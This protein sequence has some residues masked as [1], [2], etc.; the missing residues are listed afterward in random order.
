MASSTNYFVTNF[1]VYSLKYFP[2]L[3]IRRL[4]TLV[5]AMIKRSVYETPTQWWLIE[6]TGVT[7]RNVGDSKAATAP[8]SSVGNLRE[9]VQLKSP[10]WCIKS[11][12]RKLMGRLTG[13]KLP[14]QSSFHLPHE[15]YKG[16]GLVRISRRLLS[17]ELSDSCHSHKPYGAFISL[18][19]NRSEVWHLEVFTWVI[20]V[21]LTQDSND[22]I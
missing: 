18:H 19:I 16:S 11:I 21:T 2:M 22:D 1:Q 12:S 20:T 17:S 7:Y 9:T 6:F 4:F 3:S 10:T 15:L 14:F 5:K 13:T 8:G